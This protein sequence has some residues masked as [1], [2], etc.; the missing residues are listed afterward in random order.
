MI[1]GGVKVFQP[2]QDKKSWLYTWGKNTHQIEGLEKVTGLTR[3]II[4]AGIKYKRISRTYHFYVVYFLDGHVLPMQ[5][6]KSCEKFISGLSQ[7]LIWA[8]LRHD[9]CIDL[10]ITEEEQFD[11][12]M[13]KSIDMTES[14]PLHIMKKRYETMLLFKRF[15]TMPRPDGM[16]SETKEWVK[17]AW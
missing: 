3:R 17:P 4:Y 16:N 1:V 7:N 11:M 6:R 15:A 5:T 9:V 10:P 8:R 2:S 12:K 13:R 14:Q